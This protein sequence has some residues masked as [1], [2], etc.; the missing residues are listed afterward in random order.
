MAD[1]QQG[2]STHVNWHAWGC[3]YPMGLLIETDGADDARMDIAIASEV[4]TG[5]MYGGHGEAGPPR[6]VSFAPADRVSLSVD[7]SDLHH[8]P[9]VVP[10]G[11][12]D[13]RL[14]VSLDNQPTPESVQF[15]FTDSGAQPGVNTYWI[16]VRQT[17]LEMAWSSPIFVDLAASAP[18]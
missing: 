7:L 16:R 17:D 14:T 18:D 1:R 2:A 15:E 3:G 12:L 9:V 4:L 10:L 5:P 6:R 11:V 13:R 8:G